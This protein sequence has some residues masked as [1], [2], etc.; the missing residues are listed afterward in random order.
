MKGSESVRTGRLVGMAHKI[1]NQR[2]Q[3]LETP[4]QL[5]IESLNTEGRVQSDLKNSNGN[6]G[7]HLGFKK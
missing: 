3:V 4:A 5:G 7:I 2:H 6:M 1:V